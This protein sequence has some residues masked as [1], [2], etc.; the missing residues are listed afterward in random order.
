[1]KSS[2]GEYSHT[3]FTISGKVTVRRRLHYFIFFRMPETNGNWS[4]TD[5]ERALT[6]IKNGDMGFKAAAKAF[7]VP[8]TTL[9]RHYKS[10]NKLAKQQIVHF[11]TH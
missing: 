8:K 1:M 6:S 4:Q 10:Q 2:Y 9:V 11:G 3:V 7:F 5:L